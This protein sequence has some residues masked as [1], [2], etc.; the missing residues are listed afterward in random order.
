MDSDIVT[1]L[2]A[3]GGLDARLQWEAADEIERLRNDSETIF[4]LLR[5]IADIRQAAGI[6]AKVMLG[7]LPL[8]IARRIYGGCARNQGATQ[9][10]AEAVG[11][12]SRLKLAT[13]ERDWVREQL[14]TAVKER[15]KARA[16]FCRAMVDTQSVY[17]RQDGETVLVTDPADIARMRGWHLYRKDGTNGD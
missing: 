10:C 3:N 2:R 11:L 13:V 16:L 9:H 6:G 14:A 8:E 5:T 17:Q 4:S 7:D 15:D 12:E 1:R